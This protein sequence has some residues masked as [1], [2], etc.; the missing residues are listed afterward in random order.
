MGYRIK[1]VS[2]ITGI[3]KNTL[4]AWE[5]RYGIPDPERLANG[6]R[7]YS[8][9]DIATLQQLKSAIADG[10]KISEAVGLVR[11]HR[12][13]RDRAPIAGS[14]IAV[15]PEQAFEPLIEELLAA[16]E[17][18]DRA[19]AETVVGRLVGTP[20]DLLIDRVYFP[21]LRRVGDRWAAGQISVAQEH[22]ASA[23]VR[24][25]LIAM[26]LRV[27]CGP[28]DGRHVACV[29][30][31]GEQHELGILGLAVHL[32][33]G[34]CRVTYLGADLPADEL[35][36]FADEQDPAWLCVSVIKDT[37]ADEIVSYAL[38]L[39]RTLEGPRIA[40]GGVALRGLDLPAIEGVTFVV[41]WHD[42][43][44]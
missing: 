18:F 31:P 32:A 10:L 9:A 37:P 43:S 29:T 38:E 21:L 36:H 41:D 3:P 24:D 28:S 26:L 35:G 5:R 40:I 22:F 13:H 12:E 7:Q 19:A 23:F 17:G 33:L 39:R 11:D 6:Y 30:F 1:T 15:A 34:G 16:L 14:A 27:G 20:D 4:V 42:L 8:D 44:I 2:E 25:Q